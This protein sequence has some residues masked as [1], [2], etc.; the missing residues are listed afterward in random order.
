LASALAVS[1]SSVALAE[2]VKLKEWC[3]WRVSDGL[4][5]PLAKKE[6]QRSRFSRAEPVPKERRPR[7]VGDE[8]QRDAR[9]RAFFTFAVDVRYGDGG[10]WREDMTGCVYR[11]SGAIYVSIG[12]EYFPSDYLLGKRSEAVK[13]VCAA[14]AQ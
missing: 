11:A 14:K 6:S 9:D 10:E 2:D 1:L 3:V 13:G 5:K 8:L 4:L 7:A 12:D